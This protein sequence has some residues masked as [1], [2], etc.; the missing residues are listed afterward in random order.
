MLFVVANADALKEEPL[1]RCIY[2]FLFKAGKQY[3]SHSDF[4]K[5]RCF[6]PEG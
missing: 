6:R 5:A 2:E 1:N 3:C 4:P